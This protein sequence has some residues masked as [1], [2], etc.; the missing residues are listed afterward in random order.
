M[1]VPKGKGYR[2]IVVG[3][4][5]FKWRFEDRI[6][7]VPDGLAG[8]RVLDIDFGWFDCWLYVNDPTERPPE[9]SPQVATPAFVSS[10]IEFALKNGWNTDVRGGRFMLKYSA[11]DGFQTSTGD[12]LPNK[13]LQG[14]APPRGNR[15]DIKEPL[16]RRAR[17]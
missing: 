2:R 15:I 10:A 14:T 3:G 1:T 4:R 17:R 7:V 13:P 8:R 12:V 9:F 16:V 5:R 6:V 11:D